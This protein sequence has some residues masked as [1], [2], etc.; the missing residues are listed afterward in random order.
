[1]A[2]KMNMTFKI[3][4]I[5]IDFLNRDEITAMTDQTLCYGKNNHLENTH[6]LIKNTYLYNSC[7]YDYGLHDIISLY[8][9]IQT[10][11]TPP[12]SNGG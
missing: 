6:N 12:F 3:P 1:M 8:L 9:P 10:R 4:Y 11:A 5:F 7:I 2:H